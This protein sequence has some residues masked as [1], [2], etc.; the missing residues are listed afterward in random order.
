VHGYPHA[1]NACF[2]LLTVAYIKGCVNFLDKGVYETMKQEEK[3]IF[4]ESAYVAKFDKLTG[5]LQTQPFMEA[6]DNFIKDHDVEEYAMISID[7]EHFKLFNDWYGW[8]RGDEYLIDVAKRLKTIAKMKN[9]FAGYMGGD[10][11]ALFIEHSPNGIEHMMREIH[12]YGEEIGNLVGFLPGAGLY[13]VKGADITAA[14]AMYDRAVLAQNEIKGNYV[15]RYN[16][17]DH[18]L[19]R[20]IRNEMSIISDVQKGIEEH[21]FVAYMQP[22][23]NLQTGKIVGAESLVRWKSKKRGMIA[24]GEFIPI[25]EKNG[26]IGILDKYIWEEVCAWQRSRIDRGKEILAVS[27]NVSRVDIYSG[28]VV[29]FFLEMTEKY[30]IPRSCIKIEITESSYAEDSSRIAMTAERF[31]EE[32][33]Q[34]YM[35]DFGSGYSSLNMLKNIYVDALKVDMK[36]LELD[37]NNAKKGESIMESVINMARI[38]NIPIIVEGAETERQIK[39]IS[40]MGCRYVQGYY[41]YHPMPID[42]LEKLLETEAVDYSGLQMKLVE[43]VHARELLDENLFTDTVV[44]NI[45]GAVAFYDVYDGIVELQRVNE[46]FYQ[47]MHIEGVAFEEYKEKMQKEEYEAHQNMFFD[48]LEEAYEN[49]VTGAQC[50]YVGKAFDGSLLYLHIRAFFLRESEGHRFFYVG[51]T[52]TGVA[53]KDYTKS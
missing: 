5:L 24:P 50:N 19:M 9:G 43:P 30:E 29:E 12:E 46:Q 16:I 49:S 25:L 36:F 18:A 42:E 7:I 51:F 53:R 8:K 27:V 33:F 17:Y 45:L 41:Y 23:V 52:D 10:N 48:L 35:D 39:S 47:V 31:R 20:G 21:E 4:Y 44:N 13:L 2:I 37:D 26:F 11:F 34:V 1:L 28:D 40:A 32:G 6:V 38:L 22:Q 3:T 14:S 15:K